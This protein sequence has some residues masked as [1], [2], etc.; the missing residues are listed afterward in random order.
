MDNRDQTS[1]RE[2]RLLK[3]L[4]LR[5]PRCRLRI[6]TEEDIPHVYSAS[7]TAGFNDGMLW[8]PPA[9]IQELRE[10]YERSL[11]SWEQGTAYSFSID[12]LSTGKFIGRISIRKT[13]E[14]GVWNIGFWTHPTQ[15]GRGFMWEAT[16]AII[17]LG[18]EKLDAKRIEACHALWNV[19]S[20]KLLEKVGMIFIKHIPEGF[21]KRG[22]WV[23]ENLMA[24]DRV[25]WISNKASLRGV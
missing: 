1:C 5:T 2:S 7:Q 20:Q 21:Q 17:E 3:D 11:E 10:P 18:F 13:D 6:P 8:D 25:N 14:A 24:I 19:G 23:A 15:Q 12:S 9:T 22:E 16:S 4:V